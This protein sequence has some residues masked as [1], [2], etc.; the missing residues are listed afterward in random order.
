VRAGRVS[1]TRIRAARKTRATYLLLHDEAHLLQLL[2]VQQDLVGIVGSHVSAVPQL[3]L[4][5]KVNPIPVQA[6]VRV[7]PICAVIAPG[8]WFGLVWVAHACILR[9]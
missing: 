4:D 1:A 6:V 5:V 2:A 9:S 7:V 3:V 8:V